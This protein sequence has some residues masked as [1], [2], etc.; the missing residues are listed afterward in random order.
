MKKILWLSLMNIYLAS[1]PGKLT[2][3]REKRPQSHGEGQKTQS[4]KTKK[5]KTHK[6]SIYKKMTTENDYPI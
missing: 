5:K 2:E 6:N 4:E 3:I 1:G